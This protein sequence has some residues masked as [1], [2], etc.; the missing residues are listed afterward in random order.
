MDATG[1]LGYRR[2][3][4]FNDWSAPQDGF[5][6]FKVTQRS[7]ERC[8]AANGYLEGADRRENLCVRTAVHATR[9]ALDGEG[10]DLCAPP[11]SQ[12]MHVATCDHERSRARTP[13]AHVSPS[14]WVRCD[15]RLRRCLWR[16]VPTRGWFAER[17]SAR[18]RRRGPAQCGCRPVTA[19]THAQRH[20]PSFSSRGRRHTGAQGS[21]G[22]GRGAG[23]SPCCPRLMRLQEKGLRYG[24]DPSL[25]HFAAQP[26]HPPAL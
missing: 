11:R 9:I 15:P 23:G 14:D 16:R 25:R 26:S 24:R 10:D 3:Q 21:R 5:G 17:C 12:H 19:A 22:S 4:D 1:K 6:R 8:S 2:N 20:W 18:S 13:I 7:G